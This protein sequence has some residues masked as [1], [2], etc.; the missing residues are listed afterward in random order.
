MTDA[1]LRT[2]KEEYIKLAFY[3]QAKLPDPVL[4]MYAADLS[5]LPLAAVL[6][7]MQALRRQPGRRTC[8]LPGDVAERAA[9]DK[10]SPDAQAND[11]AGRIVGS[12]SRFGYTNEERARAH[13]GPVGWLIV[14]RSGGW[15]HLCNTLTTA[16]GG[17]FYAQCRDQVRAQIQMGGVPE[18]SADEP[19]RLP[20][21]NARRGE[22]TA[23]GPLVGK[24]VALGR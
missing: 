22:L 19:L 6:R 7:A 21:G 16:Q 11:I 1:E 18:T 24:I 17:T 4:Q 3:F 15:R 2:L 20:Q 9:P 5:H 23:A 12:I 8:P 14:E 13:I 10:A